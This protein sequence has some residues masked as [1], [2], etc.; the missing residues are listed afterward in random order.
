MCSGCYFLNFDLL[1][2]YWPGQ[3]ELQRSDRKRWHLLLWTV[4]QLAVVCVCSADEGS[5]HES[6]VDADLCLLPKLLG[7]VHLLDMSLLTGLTQQDVVA[8]GWLWL[9]C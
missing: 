2:S 3:I 4:C 8:G 6:P 1:L 7:L 5:C 9:A